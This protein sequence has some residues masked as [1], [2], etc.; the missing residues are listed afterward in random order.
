MW[1]ILGEDVDLSQYSDVNIITG[2]VKLY[3]RELPIPLITF[4]AYSEIKRITGVCVC[5]CVCIR[6][7][8]C[9]W[10]CFHVFVCE[11][12][13]IMLSINRHTHL[14]TLQLVSQIL[15]IQTWTGNLLVMPSNYYRRCTTSHS[16][17]WRNIWTS[18]IIKKL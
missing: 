1:L 12:L 18:K 6:V 16:N 17:T 11:K 5:V 14:H 7:C 10:V 2:V 13:A 3:L 4:D 8:I 15:M 9:V